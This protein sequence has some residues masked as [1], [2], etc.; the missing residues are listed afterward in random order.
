MLLLGMMLAAGGCGGGGGDDLILA[1]QGFNSDGITQ[2]DAVGA[3]TADIDVCQG[4][5]GSIDA[6]TVEPFTQTRVNAVFVNRGK[7]DIVIR[8]YTVSVPGSGVPDQT[9][10]VSARIPGGRCGVQAQDQCAFDDE[11][12]LVAVCTHQ[13]TQVELLL[14]DFTFKSL[15][16]DGQCP[17]FEDP[18][19]SVI[20]HTRDVFVTF[21]GE[22]E[23][24]ENFTV[25]AAYQATFDNFSTCSAG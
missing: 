6:P 11:C 12:G 22:D 7:A 4:F 16:V 3:N 14:F 23:S 2:S 18:F 21:R 1:F 5:C 9:F 10:S 20:S 25:R 15:V 13:E 24:D 17:S 19:G 8:S